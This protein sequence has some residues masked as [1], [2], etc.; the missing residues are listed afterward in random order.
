MP[1]AA[2]ESHVALGSRV[3]GKARRDLHGAG[4]AFRRNVDDGLVE[5]PQAIEVA[6]VGEPDARTGHSLAL[7]LHGSGAP[8]NALR[9]GERHPGRRRRQPVRGLE[10]DVALDVVGATIGP[11][12]RLIAANLERPAAAIVDERLERR[13]LG[14]AV[15][16]EHLAAELDPDIPRLT[17]DLDDVAAADLRHGLGV[18]A[19]D[20]LDR[21]L[22]RAL[23]LQ[24]PQDTGK[25]HGEE[26]QPEPCH[27]LPSSHQID[28]MSA[29]DP[30]KTIRASV[31]SVSPVSSADPDSAWSAVG[32]FHAV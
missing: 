8:Q 13:E 11:D 10:R 9:L 28:C 22:N 26:G 17:L 23:A 7:E 5:Q 18:D 25:P 31:S 27:P 30:E 4:V 2:F 19:L 16:V 6:I 20:G 15:A 1:N 3:T 24:V 29:E 21:R 32:C 14:L 12:H